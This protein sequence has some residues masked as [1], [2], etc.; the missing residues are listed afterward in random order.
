MSRKVGLHYAKWWLGRTNAFTLRILS[1]LFPFSFYG[2]VHTL[3]H[4][5]GQPL[6]ILGQLS[7]LC[8]L[9]TPCS[10]PASLLAGQLEKQKHPWLC[11]HCS[12]TTK[13]WIYYQ[14][15]LNKKIWNIAPWKLLWRKLALPQTKP[16]QKIYLFR[17][18]LKLN[19]MYL[20]SHTQ[21]QANKN[22]KTEG[23]KK[24]KKLLSGQNSE[25]HYK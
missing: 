16:S 11:K 18:S 2:W 6:V 24:K 7:W 1:S 3:P 8:S 14:P 17:Q 4:G 19:A 13:T 12:A 20:K 15:F 5:M 9:S 21:M 25:R 22:H 23:T 10:P